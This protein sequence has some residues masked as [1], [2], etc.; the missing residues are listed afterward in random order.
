MAMV[1]VVILMELMTIIEKVMVMMVII[2]MMMVVMAMRVGGDQIRSVA[3]S[4]PTLCDPMNRST[5][6]L[7]VH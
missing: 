3:Q 6:G 1:V 7:P 4:C 5:L 2:V